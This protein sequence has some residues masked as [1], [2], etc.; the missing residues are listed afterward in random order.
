MKTH[1]DS[2][3]LVSVPIRHWWMAVYH[4]HGDQHSSDKLNNSRVKRRLLN[5]NE[6]YNHISANF[7]QCLQE[8]LLNQGQEQGHLVDDILT[9]KAGFVYIQCVSNPGPEQYIV[10]R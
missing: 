1:C 4:H 9:V 3:A 8:E 5:Q 7:R 10:R 6:P 2:T